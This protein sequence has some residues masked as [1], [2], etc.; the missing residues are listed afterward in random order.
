MGLI[1]YV[2]VLR[3][4]LLLLGAVASLGLLK[5]SGQLEAGVAKAF[6]ILLMVFFGN[7][8]WTIYNEL[9]DVEVDRVNK[10][11]K[12]LPSGQVDEATVLSLVLGCLCVSALANCLLLLFY[13]GFYAV[14][15]IFHACA[16]VYNAKR[17]DVLG[18]ACLGIC[19]GLMAL[20]CVY[21]IH[22]LFPLAFGLFTIA[23]NINQ[24][25]QDV[26]AERTREVI[27]LPQ[28]LGALATF[29]LT[30]ILVFLSLFAFGRLFQETGYLPILVF[31]VTTIIVGVSTSS[32]LG[33]RGR[34]HNIVE[35]LIRRL[36]RLLLLVGFIWMIF[37]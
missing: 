32:M 11:W 22:L 35:N 27:T 4:P 6:L 17:R 13:S 8:G 18:N 29:Y 15:A 28:Q 12:P 24:Q 16:Y 21:P 33:E 36:G 37:S 25:F 31:L 7:E 2:K 34:V 10:P 26:E 20:V 5:W 9:H 19:Y 14:F 1:G 23:H 30:E 3:P